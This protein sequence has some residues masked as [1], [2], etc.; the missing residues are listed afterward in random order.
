MKAL[1]T[2]LLLLAGPAAAH[3]FWLEPL[4]Y[5]LPE[6]AR[7]EA[8]ALNGE[9]FEG[10]EYSYSER[11]YAQSGVVAA[12]ERQPIPGEAG[13]RPAVSVPSLGTGLHV[14]YHASPAS[15]IVYKDMEKFETFLRGKR[16]EDALDL[17]RARGFP[18]EGIVEG[19]H[20]FVKALVAVGGGAGEDQAVGMP[21]ELVAETNPYTDSGEMVFRLLWQQTP[22]AN[23]PVFAFIKDADGAVEEILL[24]TDGEGLVRIPR[25]PGEVMVN[26]VRIV[27]ANSA[28]KERFDALWMTLWAASTYQI[29]ADEG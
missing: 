27:E 8:R 1:S 10:I 15:K 6:G 24:R 29:P 4:D 16:L 20:R 21:F 3:E 5:V 18:E 23:A 2:A 25:R 26:A 12:A 14:L 19:Y 22:D 7:I 13:Q 28:L 11:G 17:H 9:F